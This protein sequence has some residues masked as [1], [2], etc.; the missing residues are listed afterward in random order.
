MAG[1]IIRVGDPTTHGGVVIEGSATDFCHGKGIAHLGDMTTCPK[2]KGTFPIIE[3]ALTMTLYGNGIAL[4]GTRTACGAQLIATQFSDVVE[5]SRT[6]IG[7]E[8]ARG[9]VIELHP[10]NT[11]ALLQ[12]SCTGEVFDLFFLVRDD[13]TGAPLIDVPYKITLQDG[14]STVIGITDVRGRTNAI[15]SLTA[16]QAIIEVPY[17]EHSDANPSVKPECCDC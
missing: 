16:Q 5:Y 10:P 3:G 15:S 4:A 14:S 1:E 12:K 9:G 7:A 2:C 8:R 17:Y 13:Q 6:A 11:T